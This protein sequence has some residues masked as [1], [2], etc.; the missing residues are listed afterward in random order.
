MGLDQPHKG[1]KRQTCCIEAPPLRLR[2]SSTKSK[3]LAAV[4]HLN[5]QFAALGAAEGAIETVQPA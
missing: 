4:T 1:V 2:R 5:Q 3:K